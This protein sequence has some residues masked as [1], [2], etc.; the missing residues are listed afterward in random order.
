MPDALDFL[1]GFLSGVVMTVG[2]SLLVPYRHFRDR[3]KLEAENR[4]ELNKLKDALREG[5]DTCDASMRRLQRLAERVEGYARKLDMEM[6]KEKY[7]C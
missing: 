2:L 4:L 7:K 3:R 5:V 1:F 6:E